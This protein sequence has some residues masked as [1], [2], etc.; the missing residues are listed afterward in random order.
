MHVSASVLLAYVTFISLGILVHCQEN[1]NNKTYFDDDQTRPCTHV[2]LK[3]S[4]T[5]NY[6]KVGYCSTSD[7]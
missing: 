5:I 2:N 7:K 3:L 1:Y 6:E 4:A